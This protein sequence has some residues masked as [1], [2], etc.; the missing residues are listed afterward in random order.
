MTQV[1]FDLSC[2]VPLPGVTVSSVRRVVSTFL[3]V[4]EK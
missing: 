1:T 2:D 3:K 4:D